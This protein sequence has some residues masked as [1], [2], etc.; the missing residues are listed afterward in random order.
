MN[1]AA[2][3]G[4]EAGGGNGGAQGFGARGRTWDTVF[5]VVLRVKESMGVR[6]IPRR[7]C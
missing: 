4:R 6:L 1:I 5:F 2:A 7:E 3:G